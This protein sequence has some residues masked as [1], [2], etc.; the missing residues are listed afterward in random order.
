MIHMRSPF[1]HPSTTV[2]GVTAAVAG[3]MA[4]VALGGCQTGSED[5]TI[6]TTNG[7]TTTVTTDK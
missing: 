2:A 1:V 4:A 3:V 6:Q 7:K 5:K